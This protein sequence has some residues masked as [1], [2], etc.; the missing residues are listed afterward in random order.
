MDPNVMMLQPIEYSFLETKL[1]L[2]LRITPKMMSSGFPQLKQ[3]QQPGDPRLPLILVIGGLDPR[4]PLDSGTTVLKYHPL[5]VD[6][7]TLV[8]LMPELRSYHGAAHIND[9]IF[10]AGGC[11]TLNRKSGDMTITKTTFTMDTKTGRG[12]RLYT[13][14]FG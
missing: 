5:I 7:W 11:S 6:R 9:T 4:N 13:G 1:S 8:S 12:E 2:G 14:H 10:V 3:M